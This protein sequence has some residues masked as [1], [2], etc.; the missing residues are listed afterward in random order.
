[1]VPA[2]VPLDRKFVLH[3][4]LISASGCTELSISL[5][6]LLFSYIACS[7]AVLLPRKLIGSII[8]IV[9][10]KYAERRDR[11]AWVP[12]AMLS[13]TS[14]LPLMR[15]HYCGDAGNLFEYTANIQ[16]VRTGIRCQ[17]LDQKSVI[18]KQLQTS[19]LSWLWGISIQLA[20]CLGM[21]TRSLPRKKSRLHLLTSK[22]TSK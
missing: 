3:L 6:I 8:N 21:M 14:K 19:R 17:S 1:M 12:S 20:F 15:L 2:N 16:S 13:L 22:V 9:G 10:L 18:R 4:H 5:F 11:L 7:K